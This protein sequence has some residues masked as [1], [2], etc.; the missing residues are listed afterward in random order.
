[1]AWVELP[2]SKPTMPC[3]VGADVYRLS[4][5]LPRMEPRAKYRHIKLSSLGVRCSPDDNLAGHAHADVSQQ[6]IARAAENVARALKN[7][8]ELDHSVDFDR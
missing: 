5:T 2:I 3:F 8:S 1:M 6:S 7:R 4:K